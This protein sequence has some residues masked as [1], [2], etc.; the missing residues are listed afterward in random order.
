MNILN[1][2]ELLILIQHLILHDLIFAA[3]TTPV[4]RR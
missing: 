4:Y 2:Q 3:G 1:S